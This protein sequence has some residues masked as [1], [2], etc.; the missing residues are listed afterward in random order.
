MIISCFPLKSFLL[1]TKYRHDEENIR[2][3][4][5]KRRKAKKPLEHLPKTD[6]CAMIYNWLENVQ[7]EKC[8]SSYKDESDDNLSLDSDYYSEANTKQRSFLNL[9]NFQI[10]EEKLEGGY[11]HHKILKN[12][13]KSIKIYEN[14][15]W[16]PQTTLV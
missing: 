10:R 1:K 12:N 13:Q 11:L 2:R 6:K 3:K 4:A 9:H 15:I 16:R 14:R 7:N 5:D 8:N